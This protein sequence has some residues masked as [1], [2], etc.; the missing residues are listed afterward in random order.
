MRASHFS[1]HGR[2]LTAINGAL[3][4]IAILLMVQIWLL[5][6]TLDAYLS[7]HREVALPGAIM[8]GIIFAACTGLYLF[9][10]RIESSTKDGDSSSTL[11]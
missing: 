9:V 10:H 4:L 1:R 7:G 11:K 6:A 3:A 8:S 2:G 5:S